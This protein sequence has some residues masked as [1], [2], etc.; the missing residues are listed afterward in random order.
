MATYYKP[1]C[2]R[3]KRLVFRSID[4]DEPKRERVQTITMVVFLVVAII[5]L[6]RVWLLSR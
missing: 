2:W 3:G 4:P 1:S 5:S 6:A